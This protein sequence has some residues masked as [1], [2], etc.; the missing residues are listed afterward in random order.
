MLKSDRVLR[1]CAASPPHCDAADG[2]SFTSHA[3][4]RK[5][6]WSSETFC[7]VCFLFQLHIINLIIT[8]LI[9]IY[10][11]T[12]KTKIRSDR[13]YYSDRSDTLLLQI[14]FLATWCHREELRESLQ[15]MW[16]WWRRH[17]HPQKVW[18]MRGKSEMNHQT[19]CTVKHQRLTSTYSTEVCSHIQT[20]QNKIE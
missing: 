18:T 10:R 20:V 13:F 12:E 2:P 14:R 17:H 9:I 16:W 15:S 8:R 6:F 1:L 19:L 11:T 7:V 5:W 3:D 4:G